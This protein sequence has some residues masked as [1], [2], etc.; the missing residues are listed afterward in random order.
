MPDLPARRA[1]EALFA[2]M[3]RLGLEGAEDFFR[4][5]PRQIECRLLAFAARRRHQAERDGCLAW[6]TGRYVALGVHA[7]RR[8]PAAPPRFARRAADAREMKD[9]FL[10]LAERRNTHDA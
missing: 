2:Q 10:S 5:T 6:L 9:L 3:A 8:Y 7:P 1:Y 4:L